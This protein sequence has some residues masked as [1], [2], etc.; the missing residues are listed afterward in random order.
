M[1]LPRSAH[2]SDSLIEILGHNQVWEVL[3]RDH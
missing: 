3:H 2:D 1:N